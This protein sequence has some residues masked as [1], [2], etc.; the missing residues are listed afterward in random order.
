MEAAP[1]LLPCKICPR[2]RFYMAK[3]TDSQGLVWMAAQRISR[4]LWQM[5]RE[6]GEVV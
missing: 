2:Y 5:G 3:E 4:H 1:D 6:A